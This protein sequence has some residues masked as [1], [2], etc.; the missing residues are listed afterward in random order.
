MLDSREAFVH[1][2]MPLGL[3]HLIG[4]D[5]Y[6]P[7]PENTDPRRADWSATYYHRAD[8]AGIG[9][10]RTRRGSDA[11]DQYRSPLRE[12][13]SDP[14]TT[15]DELLL[16]FH[17][18]P[19]DYRMKSGRTLWDELVLTYSRG[20]EEAKGLETRWTTL[21][22]KVDEER[23]QAVLAKL[24]RQSDDAA[25]WRDKCRPAT[26]RPPERGLRTLHTCR[27]I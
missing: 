20:A 27:T 10:D 21:R 14:A 24:H 23:Y 4:G 13:W 6:A 17:R 12:Q 11:V 26:S 16:W 3:H 22:G 9:Y 18:L 5:H 25:A 2:T 1:Y 15:P 8:A 7:M 19:W